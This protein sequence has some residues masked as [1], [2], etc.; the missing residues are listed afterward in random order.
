MRAPLRRLLAALVFVGTTQCTSLRRAE[1]VPLVTSDIDHF[2]TAYPAALRDT[3]HADRVFAEHYF[4]RASPG[5][6]EYFQ[7]KYHG[8]AR[9]FARR[10]TQRPRYYASVRQT[11]LAIAD[12]KP[13]IQ[14]A[15][16]RL[17]ALYPPVR[18][19]PIYFVVGGFAGSTAQP[20]GLLIGA[21]Q[22]ANGPGWTPGSCHWSS[23]TGAGRS[24]TCP[25]W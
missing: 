7:R 11:T 24:P 19:F 12:Q 22:T 10:I 13:Q 2:W 8:D 6:R 20:P 3:A 1:P 14:A 15:F 5:L 9:L 17:Q 16:R 21:D 4:A 18:F 23:A 25:T